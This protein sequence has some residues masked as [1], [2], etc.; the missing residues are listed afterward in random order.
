MSDLG[1][2]P[3]FSV[4]DLAGAIKQTLEGAFGRVRVRG[5]ITELRAYASG[6]IYFA[7]KDESAKIRAI[8]W[9]GVAGRV[10]LKPEN[11]VEVIATGKITS[12]PE[13]SEYQLIIERLEYAGAGALLARIEALKVKLQAEGLFAAER[14]RPI[15]LLPQIIGVVTSAQGAVLQDI[16]TTIARRFPRPILLWPVAVQGEAAAAQI[17]AA[18][19]GFS[20]LTEAGAIPRPN[21]LIVA[22]GGGSLEDLMAFNDEAVLRAV[23]NCS[24]PVIS[25]VGHETDTTLIDFVSDRRAPTPTAAAE[26]A[27]PPRLELLADIAQK[28]ARLTGALSHIATGARA[29]LDRASGKLPDLPNLIGAARQRL[30]DRAER[31]TLA[32][33]NYAAARRSALERLANRL[34]HPR[35]FLA[36]QR[37]NFSLLEH[38]LQVP[39]PARLRESRLRLD[40]LATRLNS[41]SYESVLRRG[42]VLVTTPAGTPILSAAK[43]APGAALKLKFHDG[44]IAATAAAKQGVLDL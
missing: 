40:N 33:P 3:E 24:I 9:R 8:I 23:A 36:A 44:D 12:Y 39:L 13:R 27:V 35:E 10:G 31:L 7:L 38:R 20:A 21:V 1:N 6:H 17:A 5:E 37:N 18:I 2:T 41:V 43:I 11:G 25:A 28:T 15:P 26:M 4:S 16:K 30:D 29:R 22:R 34:I 32:L 14:K 19:N 42:F